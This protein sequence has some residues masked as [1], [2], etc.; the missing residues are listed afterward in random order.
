VHNEE[1]KYQWL[2]DFD[3]A[4]HDFARENQILKKAPKSIWLDQM[5]KLIIFERNGLLFVF[6]LHPNW[7]QDGVYVDCKK[8]GA[9]DYRVVFSSDE[10]R[11]GGLDRV[12]Y[13]Y[14]YTAKKDKSGTGFRLYVPCRTVVVLKKV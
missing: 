8:T 11:F 14:T 9:G 13:D 12:S 10:G 7:S 6:N 5:G 2:A 3:R 4:M 1:L